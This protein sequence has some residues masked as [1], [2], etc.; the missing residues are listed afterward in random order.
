MTPETAAADLL[1]LQRL[2]GRASR[3]LPGGHLQTLWP[4][5]QVRLQQRL[6]RIRPYER[7]RWASPDADFIEVD[8]QRV[9]GAARALLV[10]FHGLEGSS[11]SHYARAFAQTAAE[12]GLDFAVPHF[13]GC[14]GPINL[15]PRAYHSG[16]HEEID[17]IVRRM[18]AQT[19]K[20]LL[21]LG[22]SLG[23]NALLRWAQEHGEQ[24]GRLASALASVSAP[25]DLQASGQA[26]DRGFNKQVYTRAFLHTMKPKA[27][28]KL[29]QFPGLFDA[30]A[31]R[32]LTTLYAFDNLVTAPLHGFRNTDDYWHRA[33]AKPAMDAIRVP[34]LVVNACNDPF[35][36]SGSLPQAGSVGRFVTLCQPWLGG[37]VG[38]VQGAFPGQW[39]GMSQ[40]IVGWMMKQAAC[41]G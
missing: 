40:E 10:L 32:A 31:L 19:S 22:V 1:L 39:H 20:P 16:D 26:M 30:D 18:A 14:S 8:W 28:Q 27:M 29:A 25:L 24:A 35:V 17:W 12:L 11:Q 33:S 7:E 9:P 21:L 6:G 36:P 37:H 34:T 13:R 4:A 3:W 5:V 23:G 41:D 2:D 15:A 38:F